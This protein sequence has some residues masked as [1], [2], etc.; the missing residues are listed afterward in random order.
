MAISHVD[1]RSILAL[2]H[3]IYTSLSRRQVQPAFVPIHLPSAPNQHP[4]LHSQKRTCHSTACPFMF[5]V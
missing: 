2:I 1:I 5:C 3:G 4:D